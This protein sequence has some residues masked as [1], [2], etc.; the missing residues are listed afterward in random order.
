LSSS[1]YEFTRLYTHFDDNEHN[2][3]K[4]KIKSRLNFMIS[5]AMRLAYILTPK[6]AAE[7][8]FFDDDKEAFMMLG[9]NSLRKLIQKYPTLYNL[10]W[11]NS[12]A[13]CRIYQSNKRN[14]TLR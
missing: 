12:Y 1:Y 9:Q 10:K 8:F 2:N 11:C 4:T 6:Y 7:G 5:D 14:F 3:V 13:K